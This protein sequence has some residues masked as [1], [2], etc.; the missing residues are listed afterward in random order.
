MSAPLVTCCICCGIAGLPFLLCLL[1]HVLALFTGLREE[2]P[3]TA[4]AASLN[5]TVLIV[6]VSVREARDGL[7]DRE[8]A[9]C[10][11]CW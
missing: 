2:A 3:D 9:G 10:A 1:L 4:S 8:S 6:S 7:T 11:H 5:S